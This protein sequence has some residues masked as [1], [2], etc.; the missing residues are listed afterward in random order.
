MDIIIHQL[1]LL[2]IAFQM[3]LFAHMHP[4]IKSLIQA[5]RVLHHRDGGLIPSWLMILGPPIVPLPVASPVHGGILLIL[6]TA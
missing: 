3:F 2:Q 1:Y 5:D 4:C 6:N